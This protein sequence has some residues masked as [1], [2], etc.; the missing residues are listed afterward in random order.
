MA[1]RMWK[2]S[3]MTSITAELFVWY[4]LKPLPLWQTAESREL[5]Q[6]HCRFSNGRMMLLTVIQK[7]YKFG[8]AFLLQRQL[9]TKLDCLAMLEL[10]SV[11]TGTMTAFF[12]ENSLENY[13]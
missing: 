6:L 9:C 11:I 1:H 5:F 2:Y 7:R 4:L 13:L 3:G 10:N 8:R 12:L